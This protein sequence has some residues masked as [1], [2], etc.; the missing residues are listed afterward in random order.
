[1]TNGL[2]TLVRARARVRA[3]E[4][5][6]PRLD[7]WRQAREVYHGGPS[8]LTFQ[9]KARGCVTHLK[10]HTLSQVYRFTLSART[11][12][13]TS[14]STFSIQCQAGRWCAGSNVTVGVVFGSIGAG[15]YLSAPM[16]LMHRASGLR[17]QRESRGYAG[18]TPKFASARELERLHKNT[19]G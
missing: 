18:F 15:L 7:L 8:R 4:Q 12:S 11:F 2:S 9:S 16:K 17:T 19:F 13:G 3:T 10:T 14:T 6:T 5:Q 1:M